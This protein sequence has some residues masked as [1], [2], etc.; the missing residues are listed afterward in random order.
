MLSL[1]KAAVSFKFPERRPDFLSLPVK[2]SGLP[3][4]VNLEV[5]GDFHRR[6]DTAAQFNGNFIAVVLERN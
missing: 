2:G 6:S 5:V 4:K 1:K 3:N